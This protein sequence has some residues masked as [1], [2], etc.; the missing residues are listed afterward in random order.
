MPKS[1]LLAVVCLSISTLSAQQLKEGEFEPY[2]LAV[3]DLNAADFKQAIPDL[4]LWQSKFPASEFA[5]IRTAFFVQ[6]YAGLN[7]PAKA[8]QAAR[9]LLDKDL[10]A[11]FPGP[12]GQTMIIR[13]LYNAT[14]AIAHS[15]DPSP[16]D[17][18]AG[19]KAARALMAYDDPLPGVAADKWAEARADMKK[20]A[21]A[22]FLYLAMLPGI[23]AMALHPPDCATADAAYTKSLATWPDKTALSYE[24][25]R[26]LNCETKPSAALYEFQR[27]AVLDPTLGNPAND[28]KKIKAFADNAYIKFH[29]SD[30]G[31][32]QLRTQ[33]KQSP[34]PPA[35]FQGEN[36]RRDRGCARRQ[37]GRGTS[38]TRPLE[39]NPRRPRRARRPQFF[40]RELK[41]AAVPRLK[42]KLIEAK[43]ACR[44]AELFIAIT[45]AQPE[46][47]LKLDKPLTGKPELNTEIEWEG[48]GAAFTP[49]PFRLTMETSA[50][51]LHGVKTSPCATHRKP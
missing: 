41:D 26:A 1:I 10:K 29:G 17:I 7:Q 2:S 23:R 50:D 9:P 8:L 25:G 24:L 21:N 44:S 22:A 18:A 11:I 20:K 49:E 34:L 35:R 46:V 5:N 19:D 13:L 32:D 48:A 40:D 47:V 38:R 15:T 27:A 43:P 6:T 45:G 36:R 37:L 30:E 3:K 12:A 39:A 28:P 14:W 16:D 51:Q 33:V 42:G 4:E 31:L